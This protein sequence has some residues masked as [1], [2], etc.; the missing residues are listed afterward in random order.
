MR[1]YGFR[2][3]FSSRG[4]IMDW[5]EIDKVIR[6]IVSDIKDK[7]IIK[8]VAIRDNI[9]VIVVYGYNGVRRRRKEPS[10]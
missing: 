10:R 1:L 5:K 2:A 6:K 9:F 4:G 8:N 3:A 7:C